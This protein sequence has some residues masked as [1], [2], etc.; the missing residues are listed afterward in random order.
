MAD[1][2]VSY[3]LEVVLCDCDKVVWFVCELCMQPWGSRP[4]TLLIGRGRG[5]H[6]P[7]QVTVVEL[8]AGESPPAAGLRNVLSAAANRARTAAAEK[9]S[10]PDRSTVDA[11]AV[12]AAH[13]H[14][15]PIHVA[16]FDLAAHQ[17]PVRDDGGLPGSRT[18]S[19]PPICGFK[20][21]ARTG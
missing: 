13:H 2:S 20:P 8:A 6:D 11:P 7:Q 12:T 17:Q 1:L 14:I 5:F 9:N 15:E 19:W 21:L 3:L 18:R 16:G 4:S 10:T